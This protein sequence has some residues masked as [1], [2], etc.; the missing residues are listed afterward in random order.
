MHL[1]GVHAPVP[2][3]FDDCGEV[4]LVRMRAALAWWL[5]HPLAGI[6]VLGSSGEAPLV[7]E[8]DSDRVIAAAREL[9]PRGRLLVAGCGRES[10]RATMGAARRAAGLGVD[11][12]L[13]RAPGFFKAQMTSEALVRHYTAVADASPVPVLLY[14]FPAVTGVDLTA[15]AVARLATHPNVV[16]IKESSGDAARVAELVALAT[17]AFRVLVGSGATFHD[18]LVAGASGGILA[19]A[20]VI[21]GICARLFDL[22]CHGRHDEARVLQETIVPLARL[23]GSVHGVPGL[24]A[25]LRLV[26][27]DVGPP[28]AP[29]L[30]L[31]PGD[32]Q[33]LGEAI[34]RCEGI[35]A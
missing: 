34:A 28:R 24:K 3:A 2:T 31:A 16:G 30:P 4:D 22:A 26:G 8:D 5:S 23:V 29:L 19:V 15:A 13:V 17:P 1:G 7:D 32:E 14:N 9:V 33:A 11:A 10:T 21:P 25:A 6:V 27:C 35:A 12:V 20:C 18:A